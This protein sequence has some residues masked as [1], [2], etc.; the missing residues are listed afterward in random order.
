[1]RGGRS[2]KVAVGSRGEAALRHAD[3][4]RVG[5]GGRARPGSGLEL[6]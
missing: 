1:M 6:D 3:G 2:G 4:V 5:S